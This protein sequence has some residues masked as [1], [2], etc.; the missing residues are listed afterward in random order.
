MTLLYRVEDVLLILILAELI[1]IFLYIIQAVFGTMEYYN[2]Q[3]QLEVLEH[4]N[5]TVDFI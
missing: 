1:I 5:N 4:L 3:N 2:V